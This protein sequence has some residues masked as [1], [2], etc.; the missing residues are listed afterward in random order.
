MKAVSE[1]DKARSL[2][3][4]KELLDTGAISQDEYDA[5]KKEILGGADGNRVKREEPSL[6]VRSGKALSPKAAVIMWVGF[7]VSAFLTGFALKGPVQWSLAALFGG[8]ALGCLL[9]LDP[10][11]LRRKGKMFPASATWVICIVLAVAGAL[12]LK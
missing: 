8:L 11:K 10:L 5:K 7:I 12:L 3:A 2:K 6:S 4:Y 9:H 1:S